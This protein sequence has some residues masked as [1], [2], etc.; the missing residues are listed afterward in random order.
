MLVL[1]LGFMV[2]RLSKVERVAIELAFSTVDQSDIRGSSRI[3]V[4]RRELPHTSGA[5]PAA[6]PVA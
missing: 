6:R 5:G 4:I 2:F 3:I 1:V